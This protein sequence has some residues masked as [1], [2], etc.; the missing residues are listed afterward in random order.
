MHVMCAT[1]QPAVV[2]VDEIDSLL[3]KRSSGDNEASTRIKVTATL[4]KTRPFLPR[5]PQLRFPP[6]PFASQ[7]ALAAC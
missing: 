6:L 3:T 4:H 5:F 7:H 1:L 2:F